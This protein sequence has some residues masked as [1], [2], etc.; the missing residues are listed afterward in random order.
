MTKTMKRVLTIVLVGLLA[1]SASVLGTFSVSKADAKSEAISD[2]Q[3]IV[4]PLP[5]SIT[6]TDLESVELL[7]KLSNARA[8]YLF[9]KGIGAENDIDPTAK[10]K[11]ESL[12]N[13]VGT[14]IS[15][16][17]EMLSFKAYVP[18]L[19]TNYVKISI[20]RE[21]EINK[22]KLIYDAV[23][24]QYSLE[25]R[26]TIDKKIAFDYSED[27]NSDYVA[28]E[29]E[30]GYFDRLLKLIEE[31]KANIIDAKAKIDAIWEEVKASEKPATS[32]NLGI[33]K[34]GALT[35][36]KEAIDKVVV[37]DWSQITNKDNVNGVDGYTYETAEKIINGHIQTASQL[38]D[39]IKTLASQLKY[40]TPPYDL[41][42][43]G[44]CYTSVDVIKGFNDNKFTK[45]GATE[46][47]GYQ[48]YFK[49]THAD[50]YALLEEMLAHCAKVEEDIKN[51][52]AL[53]EAIEGVKY[54]P[55]EWKKA[56]DAAQ[57]AVDALDADV[58][59]ET[60]VKISVLEAAK[61]DYQAMLDAIAN[62]VTIIGA[63]PSDITLNAPCKA[64]IDA[65]RTAYDALSDEYK[66]NFPAD[67]LAKL[68]AAE[69]AYAERKAIV[70]TWIENVVAFYKDL[71]G[72]TDADKIQ[73]IWAADLDKIAQ[74]EGEYAGFEDDK[75]AYVDNEGATA[76]LAEIKNIA[77]VI[78]INITQGLIDALATTTPDEIVE[79]LLYAKDKYDTLHETQQELIDNTVLNEKWAKYQAVS[80]FDKAVAAIKANVDAGSYFEQDAA[81]MNT[82]F[83]LYNVLDEEGRAM[84]KSYADLLAIEVVLSDAELI[85]VYEYSKELA[86][87][88][89]ALTASVN[90][91][92]DDLQA[93]IN[94]LSAALE[95][96][97]STATIAMVIAIIAT[98]AA[99]VGIVLVFTK[100]N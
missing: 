36:A 40:T 19:N 20:S 27:V 5:D 44:L 37:D 31:A 4:I 88:I 80:Y 64:A 49:T 55:V 87:K 22:L 26:K 30:T 57:I 73:N 59:N 18:E 16:Y 28:N 74:L 6:N 34:L 43:D 62:V 54:V 71:E 70:D 21:G 42:T 1:I 86:Q 39:S 38:A 67:E 94:D 84:V 96:A 93:Q 15:L 60:Y 24:G 91:A 12:Q 33:D 41:P 17:S 97:N 52:N 85:D 9:L 29:C 92:K 58:K 2:F 65:A 95:K 23:P 72:A 90:D 81:L 69:K 32:E 75:K 78:N 79:K 8:D 51:A 10:A 7:E 25:V 76:E 83:V 35:A 50:A 61:A 13:K 99:I 11:W 68:E 82:L 63:I 100:K 14:V 48:Q 46:L 77:S 45:I 89:E 56:I 98:V 53:I 3:A 66:A 47:D